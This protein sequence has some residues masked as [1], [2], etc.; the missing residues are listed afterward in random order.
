MI[1]VP[2]IDPSAAVAMG[3][4]R[5]LRA[6]S[7]ALLTCFWATICPAQ[8]AIAP[9]TRATTQ[10]AIDGATTRPDGVLAQVRG[11]GI[12]PFNLSA[13]YFSRV[14]RTQ[15]HTKDRSG[16]DVTYS[17]ISMGALL[18]AAGAPIGKGRLRGSN[19][20]LVVYV[21]GADGYSAA[22]SLTEFDPDFGDRQI[23]LADRR[24]GK[25]L[26]SAEG[27]LRLV[28]PQDKR[29]ARWVR[30]VDLIEIK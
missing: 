1:D 29:P 28:V 20:R 21:I 26:S 24:D 25:P 7:I 23:L 22:F 6:L 11:S 14:P 10:P 15:L 19:L 9:T 18:Q 13:D 16:A 3:D 27:P 5:M 12:V 4:S 8:S 17:G 2:G 30:Q